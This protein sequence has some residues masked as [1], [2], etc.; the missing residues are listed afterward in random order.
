MRF[1][2]EPPYVA[3]IFTSELVSDDPEYNLAAGRM[4]LLAAEQPGFLGLESARSEEQGI[5]ISYWRNEADVKAW[6]AHPEHV[7]IRALGREAWYKRY[8]LRVAV[9]QREGHYER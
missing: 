2:A 1:S 7:E 3:V 4:A 9:V 5:T 8:T 6:R